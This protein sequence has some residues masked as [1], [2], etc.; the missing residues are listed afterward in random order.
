MLLVLAC[1]CALVIA[2]PVPAVCCIAVAAGRRVLVRGSG[3]IERTGLITTVALDKTG[4][5]TRGLFRVTHK[6]VFV[7]F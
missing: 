6:F 2:A 4:T 1:P 3:V 5:L 7:S